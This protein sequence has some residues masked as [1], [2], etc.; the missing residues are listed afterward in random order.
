MEDLHTDKD[1][2]D[3]E[4]APCTSA[5]LAAEAALAL[6]LHTACCPSSS[7][8]AHGTGTDCGKPLG[9]RILSVKLHCES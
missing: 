6:L 8:L 2:K 3:K 4:N 1:Q 7:L 9:A 5:S